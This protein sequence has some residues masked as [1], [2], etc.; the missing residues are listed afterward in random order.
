MSAHW[1]IVRGALS[2]GVALALMPLASVLFP[3]S[4]TANFGGAFL[5]GAS[6]AIG[7]SFGSGTESETRSAAVFG[8][9]FVFAVAMI[10]FSLISIQGG[11]RPDFAWGAIAG[12]IGLGGA[13][14]MG[15][16]SI[17]F[18]LLIPG[19][20][21]FGLGGAIGG[22]LSFKALDLNYGLEGLVVA[23]GFAGTLAGGLFG[24]AVAVSSRRG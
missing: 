13:G 20:I 17:R 10:L 1:L 15:G 18:T 24:A 7:F 14:A 21:V 19:A 5:L 6:A 9:G 23:W 8:F 4:I 3:Q 12:G 2:F 11:G 22:Y 16:A